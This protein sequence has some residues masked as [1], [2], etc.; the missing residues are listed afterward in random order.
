MSRNSLK[1]RL[2][3]DVKKFLDK[4]GLLKG[5]NQKYYYSCPQSV[6]DVSRKGTYEEILDE[7]YRTFAYDFLLKD[8]SIFSFEEDGNNCRYLFM[9]GV[10]SKIPFDEFLQR[11]GHVY[12][13]NEEDIQI[14]RDLYDEAADSSVYDYVKNPVYLRFDV[15]KEQYKTSCHPYAH[16]HIGLNNE[17][18]IPSSLRLTP[19]MFTSFAI[20]MTYPQLWRDKSSDS[21]LSQWHS[22][23]KRICNKVD[24]AF[25][26]DSDL[27]DL[28]LA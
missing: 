13:E 17:I 9:Q 7:I 18:R 19:E 23:Y 28:Y 25:M 16:M 14:L 2:G 4:L 1:I 11:N 21:K 20:K 27:L 8:E 5:C 26:Q 24:A 12:D 22:E 10:K 15:S 3:N 6:I